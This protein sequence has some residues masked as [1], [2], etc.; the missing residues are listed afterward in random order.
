[1]GLVGK[2]FFESGGQ[3]FWE[4]GLETRPK[5]LAC[6]RI[7]V[8]EGSKAVGLVDFQMPRGVAWGS[9]A[10]LGVAL[11]FSESVYALSTHSPAPHVCDFHIRGVNDKSR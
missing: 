5:A 3:F 6:G 11:S 1:M 8:T 4:L 7:I 9:W 2:E 10:L